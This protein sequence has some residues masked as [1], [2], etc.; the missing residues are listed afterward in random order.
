MLLTYQGLDNQKQRVKFLTFVKGSLQD[1]RVEHWCATLEESH[2]GQ[3][4][5]H[6]ALQF[7]TKVER[8]SR[9]FAFKGICPNA[10][11]NDY[12][13]APVRNGNG[14][15]RS[16]DRAFFYVWADKK[17]TQR[18]SKGQ[19]CVAG[20]YMPAWTGARKTYQVLGKWP[21]TLWKQYKLSH[22][23]Y[24]KYLHACRDGVLARKRNLEAV[25]EWDTR[26]EEDEERHQVTERVRKK[27][28]PFAP[29][30]AAVSWL[31]LFKEEADRYP[32]LLAVG[33]SRS[34]KTEWAK[35]LFKN[36]LEVKVGTLEQFPVGMK[37]FSRKLHD[38]VVLDDVRDLAWIVRHQEKLQ[39]KYDAAVEFGTTPGGQ[40]AYFRWL[41]R[42]PTVITANFTTKNLDLLDSDDFLANSGNRV[43]VRF[44][45]N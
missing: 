31:A 8:L 29:V 26:R 13:G 36:P 44:P 38:G 11:C 42:V 43:V 16:V 5:T 21:E 10:Q 2:S 37:Q 7:R 4:H 6:L 25:V 30:P 9:G 45:P 17:G 22:N 34:G 32:F 27:F 20:N 15:Q 35:G 1:W 40:C 41:Y 23:T 12:L 14:W 28:K 33:P 18:D 24:D 19:P 39:A 3:L